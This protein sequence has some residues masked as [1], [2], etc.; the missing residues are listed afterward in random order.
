MARQ[1][2]SIPKKGLGHLY[3]RAP[4]GKI[5]PIT[6]KIPDACLSSITVSITNVT[7]RCCDIRRPENPY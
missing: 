7:E 1:K 6:S 3:K 4:G 2:S 5:V